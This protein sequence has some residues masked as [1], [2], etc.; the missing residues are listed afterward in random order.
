MKPNSNLE[1]ITNCGCEFRSDSCIITASSDTNLVSCNCSIPVLSEDC[2]PDEVVHPACYP[3]T[4]I[5]DKTSDTVQSITIR[6]RDI[7]VEF[8]RSNRVSSYNVEQVLGYCYFNFGHHLEYDD[9]SM[10]FQHLVFLVAGDVSHNYKAV[11]AEQHVAEQLR[12]V[13]HNHLVGVTDFRIFKNK[14]SL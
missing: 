1:Y 10:V 2:D 6:Y 8:S 14:I 11:I 5:V 7:Y 4:I 12:H 3:V 9:R 13:T